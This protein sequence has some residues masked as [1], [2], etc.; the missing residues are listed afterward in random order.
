[1]RL[2]RIWKISLLLKL[3]SNTNKKKGPSFSTEISTNALYE[4]IGS[5]PNFFDILV[6][7]GEEVGYIENALN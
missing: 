7:P 3:H 4:V 5:L 2:R 1:M 6:I